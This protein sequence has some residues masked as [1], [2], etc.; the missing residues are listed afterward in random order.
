MLIL[1]RFF[2][3]QVILSDSPQGKQSDDAHG[4][5]DLAGGGHGDG[6]G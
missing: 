4:I 5:P 3:F 6:L 1:G 2:A